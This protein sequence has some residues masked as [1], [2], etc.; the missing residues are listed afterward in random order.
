MSPKPNSQKPFESQNLFFGLLLN[1]KLKTFAAGFY[2]FL[3]IFGSQERDPNGASGKRNVVGGALA[4]LSKNP[5]FRFFSAHSTKMALPV[6]DISH[7][8]F[9]PCGS[10]L[11]HWLENLRNKWGQMIWNEN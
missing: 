2:P 1:R 6:F 11:Y 5:K 9:E 10:V 7:E 4:V 3:S 8:P